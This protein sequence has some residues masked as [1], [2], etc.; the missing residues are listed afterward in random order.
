MAEPFTWPSYAD[1]ASR[2]AVGSSSTPF[3]WPAYARP[4][5]RYGQLTPG[6]IAALPPSWLQ[7]LPDRAQILPAD[8][9]RGVPE[10]LMADPVLPPVPRGEFAPTDAVLPM[11]YARFATI[12]L[13]VGIAD[14]VALQ[15]PPGDAHRVY[16]LIVNTHP[17]QRMF[18]N[19]QT[20]ALTTSLP[21]LENFGFYELNN[22]VPQ[23]E[24]HLIANGAATTGVLVF[25]NKSPRD[26][27]RG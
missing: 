10:L 22:V 23:D 5:I 25:G 20:P 2:G 6:Q 19:F 11:V 15:Y 12:E 26:S 14:A 24:I 7:R 16:L 3:A 27:H 9:E 13:S 1:P 8:V 18:I 21:I 17:L 4:G